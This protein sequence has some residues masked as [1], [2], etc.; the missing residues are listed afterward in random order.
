MPCHKF[1][2]D[3]KYIPKVPNLQGWVPFILTAKLDDQEERYVGYNYMPDMIRVIYSDDLLDSLDDYF[4][5][6]YDYMD[7][8]EVEQQVKE[9][10]NDT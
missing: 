8:L 5:I 9:V 1:L 6:D 7:R 10:F 3:V 4:E 2:L